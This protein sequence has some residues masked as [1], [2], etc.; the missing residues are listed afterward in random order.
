[1]TCKQFES[2]MRSE[3][4]SVDREEWKGRITRENWDGISPSEHIAHL[5]GCRDC[6]TSLFQFLDVR[7][8]LEYSSHPCFHVAYYSA[9]IPERCLDV[10]GGLYTIITDREKRRG[11]STREVIRGF[12]NIPES[13]G[14]SL[15][16]G[17]T[18]CIRGCKYAFVSGRTPILGLGVLSLIA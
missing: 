16:P 1:M 18:R 12:Q 17:P 7:H 15:V 10:D 6:Q 3:F 9:D 14:R 4:G 13:I 2:A 11:T 5:T 8:F